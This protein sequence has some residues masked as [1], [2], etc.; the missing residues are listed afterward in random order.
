MKKLRESSSLILHPFF[1]AVYPTLAVLAGSLGILNPIQAV[2]PFVLILLLTASLFLVFFLILKDAY[3]AG[4]ILS[5]LIFMLFYYG[6]SYKLPREISI[7]G[8]TLSR[9]LLILLFWA[10]F[11]PIVFSKWVWER[12][13]PQVITRVLNISS[14][15]ALLLPL[16]L[17]AVYI[18]GLASDPLT[19]WQPPDPPTIP[20]ANA[21][22]GY[23]PDIYYLIVDGYGREDVLREYYG[24]DNSHFINFLEGEGF[25]VADLSTSNYS[26]T[27][28]SLATS[29]NFEYMD[30]L[31]F[32][33]EESKNQDPLKKLMVKSKTRYILEQTGYKVY[34]SGELLFAQERDPAIVFHSPNF[35]RLT[36]LES[37][38]LETSMME[39]AIDQWDVD[40]SDY[41]YQ[42]HRERVI[43]AFSLIKKLV[44]EHSPKFTLVHIIAPHPPFVFDREGNPVEPD[45]PYNIFDAIDYVGGV[46]EY[47]TGYNDQL[48]Y[49][50]V[51]LKETIGY[52]LD[53]SD[54]PPIIIL[55]ADHGPAAYFDWE[56]SERSCIKER[57]S[58]L[59]AYYMP[60][61]MERSMY[62]SITPVN[63]F[64]IIFNEI[65]NTQLGFLVD[66]NYYSSSSLPYNFIDVS[67]VS[68]LPCDIEN[69][70]SR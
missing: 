7:L 6:Y 32:A 40:I 12:V 25:Y 24:F 42:R 70:S 39:I 65:F 38:L 5:I 16:R 57:F 17:I 54:D 19:T 28:L 1:F 34:L 3:R 51:L 67:D 8:F 48:I 13:R 41:T 22:A 2:R 30:Y 20:L 47:I 14:L 18:L 68:D 44:D 4:F 29:M 21:D 9:H 27:A 69:S 56:R 59:N 10:I 45:G 50:N 37:L 52:I 66:R 49:I 15:I 33:G 26:R 31:A 60:K 53:H 35:T 58:I 55:Q 62:E 61:V 43:D 36:V 63:T 23:K 64:R 46:E 11:L